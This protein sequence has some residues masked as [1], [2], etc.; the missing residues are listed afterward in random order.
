MTLRN[1]DLFAM[2]NEDRTAL[3]SDLP[4]KLSISTI[5]ARPEF[6]T[7]PSHCALQTN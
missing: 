2:V 3:E 6:N 4:D 1:P 5:F 7:H